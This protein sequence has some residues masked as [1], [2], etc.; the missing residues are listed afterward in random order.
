MGG[1]G[2]NPKVF[3][4]I[5]NV[6]IDWAPVYSNVDITIGGQKITKDGKL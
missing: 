2:I 1:P 6:N 3:A 5:Q 4:V